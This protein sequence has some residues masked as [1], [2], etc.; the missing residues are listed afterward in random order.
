VL[1]RLRPLDIVFWTF[2]RNVSDV[3]K[4][5]DSLSPLMQLACEGDMLNFGYWDEATKNPAEAQNRLCSLVGIAAEIGSASRVLDAGSGLCAPAVQWKSEYENSQIH[6]LNINFKQLAYSNDLQKKRKVTLASGSGYAAKDLTLAEPS[7]DLFLNAT[8]T[9]LPFGDKSLDRVIALE[10]AQHFRPLG[11]FLS[12]S[13]RVLA[14]NGLLVLAIPV[15]SRKFHP[16][17]LPFRLGLLSFTWSSEHYLFDYVQ[18]TI[19]GSGFKITG[20]DRIGH[21]VYEPLANYYMS[22]RNEIRKKILTQYSSFLEAILYYSLL[23]MKAL[24]ETEVIDY[25]IIKAR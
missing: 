24:S 8:S 19:L 14:P 15:I 10:S 22:H 12:E 7:I 2:R 1:T 3:V 17:T 5:Y 9:D 4:L 20:I 16:I 13:R 23:K 6:C 21:K 18:S 25:V 11:R